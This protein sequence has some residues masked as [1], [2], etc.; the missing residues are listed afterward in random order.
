MTSLTMR[1]NHPKAAQIA[2]EIAE[3]NWRTKAALET[4][5]CEAIVDYAEEQL[6]ERACELYDDN[7]GYGDHGDIAG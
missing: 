1:R 7:E 2:K 6:E 5:I 3:K 4:A